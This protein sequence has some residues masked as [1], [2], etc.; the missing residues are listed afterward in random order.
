VPGYRFDLGGSAHIL[1]RLTP[2]VEELGLERTGWSTWSWTRS[3]SPPSPTATRSSSTATRTA[4]RAAGAQ[5]PGRGRRLPRSGRLA[6]FARMVKDAFL[7]ARARSSWGSASCFSRDPRRLARALGTILRPVRRGGGRVLPRGEGEG[8]AGLDGRAVRPAAHRAA[9]RALPALAA[10]L[11]RGGIARPR[12][13]SGMLTQALRG[14]SRRT[15]AGAPRAPVDEILVE[16][17]RA[18]GVR[19]GRDVHRAR[20]GLP[21]RTR[22][23]VRA[24]AAAE[25]RPPGA[26]GMRPGNGFGAVLRLALDASPIRY[27]AHPGREARVGLQLLCRDRGRSGR[28]RRL[29]ARRARR[30]TR[31]SSR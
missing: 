22:G 14:T 11:P 13:G 30:A 16:G 3:S 15:A 4:P 9:D 28:L 12:G 5:V 20:G 10:A 31:R 6:P 19:V 23:D 24:A 17:G 18:V 1:I 2:I 8:A 25:H 21:A 29:P 7:S 27:A 26:A